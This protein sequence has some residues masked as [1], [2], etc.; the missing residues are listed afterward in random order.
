MNATLQCL[1]NTDKLTNYFLKEFKYDKNDDTKKI[2]NKYYRL[3]CHLW[4]KYTVKKYYALK[5]FKKVLS[6]ANPLFSGVNPIESKDLLNFLLET[7]HKELNN[8][9]KEEKED[10]NIDNNINKFSEEDI[11]QFFLKII[12][13]D[14]NQLS[15]IY[16]IF[17]LK[18]NLN[19]V[20][21]NI[22]NIILKLIHFLN[23]L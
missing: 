5:K 15:Q 8:V 21:A 4:N 1:S 7:L 23:F 22:L 9:P 20:I 12:Q 16:F 13:K 11:K 6:D 17:H 3:L 10:N 19:V 18:L 2:S 14:I